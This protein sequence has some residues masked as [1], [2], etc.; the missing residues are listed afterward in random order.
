MMN[1]DHKSSRSKINTFN[2][3]KIKYLF[4][5]LLI[6]GFARLQAQSTVNTAGGDGSGNGGSVS[7]S[8]GQMMYQTRT[9]TNE[10]AAEGVQQPYEISVLSVIEGVEGINLI[11]QAF[12]NPTSDYLTINILDYEISNLTYQLYDIQGKL[13]KN[14]QIISSQTDIEMS[15]LV[16]AT[17]IIR[18]MQKSRTLKSFKIIKN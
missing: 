1:N 11:V 16:P 8:V 15:N 18:V 2:I 9:G 12:P 6:L 10:T 17:Y 14:Q 5:L 13:I 4:F 7:F 3:L